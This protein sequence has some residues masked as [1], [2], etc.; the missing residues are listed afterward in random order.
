MSDPSPSSIDSGFSPEQREALVLDRHVIVSAAA[1]SGKTRVL[2]ERYVRLL[3]TGV[4]PHEIVAIT[5]TRKAAAEMLTRIRRRV[6]ELLSG[7]VVPDDEARRHLGIARAKLSSHRVST[8][9]AF[10]SALLRE[11][12]IE[13]GI[14]PAF[15]ELS[16][17][18]A[19]RIRDAAVDEV[20]QRWW[21]DA[22]MSPRVQALFFDIESRKVL[23]ALAALSDDALS[24]QRMRGLYDRTDEQI[25]QTVSA[26]IHSTVIR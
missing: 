2:V 22:S 25:L 5:F 17:S 16:G 13:A 4:M 21:T 24:L 11:Y 3:M 6:D 7:D 19:Q 15:S 14:P 18:D 8:I 26:A 12:A 20:I 10:C 23:G 9:H 1:G